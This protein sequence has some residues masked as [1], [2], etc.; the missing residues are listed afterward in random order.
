[1]SARRPSALALLL[2]ALA[3]LVFSPHRALAEPL[4]LWHAYRDEERAALEALVAEWSTGGEPVELLALPYDNY[5]SKLAAAIGV[6]EGPDVFIDAHERLGDYRKRGIVGSPGEAL[7]ERAAITPRALAAV[8]D[9]DGRVWGVPIGLKS[10]ALYRNTALAPAP[11]PDLESVLELAVPEGSYP[12]AYEALSAYS[13][14]PFLHAFGGRLFGPGDVYAFVGPE[15]ERSLA[16]V[17]AALDK[18]QLP[19]DADG[20]LVKE[21]FRAG[22]AAHVLSGPWLAAGLA[23]A[24]VAYAID[25]IPP[26]RDGSRPAPYLTVEAVFL[27]PRGAGRADAQALAARLASKPA[28][29]ARAARARTLPARTDVDVSGDPMLRAFLAQSEHTVILPSSPAMR[30]AW[31]PAARALRK[32]LRGEAPADVALAE[33]KRRFDDVR[34]PL[35]ARRSPA[36]LLFVV[37]LGLLSLA[38]VAAR[39]ARAGDFKARLVRSL[40]AYLW[41]LHAVVVVGLLVFV[42]LFVGAATSLFAGRGDEARYVGLANFVSILTARGGPLLASGSFYFVLAVTVLWT[43]VNLFF[44]VSI[45]VALAL[46]LHRPTLRLR[47]LYRVLLVV[48]W[49]VPTYVT[50]L[51]WKGMFHR[52]YGAIT[53]LIHGLNGALGLSLEPIAWFSKFSTAFTANALTNV[54]L[55]FPFMMVVTLGAL[56]AIPNDVLEAAEVDGATRWQRFRLVVLPMLAPSLAPSVTLGAMWTFNMFNVVFL[57]SGGDPDGSTD[58]LVSEAYR[59]AF[60]REAQYGYAA[61]YS[62]LIFFLLNGLTRLLGAGRRGGRGREGAGATSVS[63]VGAGPTRAAGAA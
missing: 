7:R 19:E 16:F 54:W 47:A 17:R 8:T 2:L 10:L 51:A 9:D 34:Q 57:V 45:G 26:L 63:D 29:E 21:L 49:A 18:R 22:K 24:K 36:P 39:R 32:V 46:L 35:P 6:G 40:P 27:S 53:G 42:P 50:A 61:A 55:G 48:P 52:Q 30:S 15:A 5:A 59:W 44:H 20:A 62:V 13:H 58:I 37:G 11:L 14:A 3:A 60:T 4:R 12:L 28:A 1:M 43:V 23:D 31:E 41:V 25:P 33:G 38:V 56:T